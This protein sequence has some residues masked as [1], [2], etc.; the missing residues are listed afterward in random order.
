MLFGLEMTGKWFATG[1]LCL[2]L[3][4]LG[5][6]FLGC[7]GTLFER[8]LLLAFNSG[9]WRGWRSCNRRT[10]LALFALRYGEKLGNALVKTREL[11]KKLCEL[12]AKRGILLSQR[13]QLVHRR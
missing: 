4:A 11:I 13:F 7:L 8:A 10:S 12:A 2:L 9:R 5:G 3:R 1:R 6:G